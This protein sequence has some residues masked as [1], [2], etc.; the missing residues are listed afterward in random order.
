VEWASYNDQGWSRRTADVI[1][2][3]TDIIDGEHKG[4][5]DPTSDTETSEVMQTCGVQVPNQVSVFDSAASKIYPAQNPMA[6]AQ[7]RCFWESSL[8]AI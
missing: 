6:S 1:N 4:K 3:T 2:E 7:L 5:D 8:S